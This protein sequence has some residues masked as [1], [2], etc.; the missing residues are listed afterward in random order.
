M[1][2]GEAAVLLDQPPGAAASAMARFIAWLRS[3]GR[4]EVTG[5]EQLWTWSVDHP[6]EF[7]PALWD[8]R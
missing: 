6:D 7:W 5:Y 3:G 4:A 1:V 2:T 8:F